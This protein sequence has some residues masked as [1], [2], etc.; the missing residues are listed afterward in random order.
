[1][2][3]IYLVLFSFLVLLPACKN[4]EEVA[5]YSDIIFASD[6]KSRNTQENSTFEKGNV[7]GIFA[8]VNGELLYSNCKYI[9]NGS[10]FEADG[11]ENNIRVVIGQNVKF[12]AYYPYSSSNSDIGNIVYT[13]SNQETKDKWLAADFL[14]ATTEQNIKGFEVPLHFEHRMAT[15]T[16]NVNQSDADATSATLKDVKTSISGNLKTG[17]FTTLENTSNLKFCKL[18]ESNGI[19]NFIITIPPQT[20]TIENNKVNLG[21]AT[22]IDVKSVKDFDAVAGKISNYILEYRKNIQIIDYEPG[23]TTSGG[24]LHVIGTECSVSV[25]LN[26][27]YEFVGW[28]DE[29]NNLLSD[30]TIYTFQVKDDITLYPK[31]RNYEDWTLSI[32]NNCPALIP[33]TGGTYNLSA[34]ATRGIFINGE[35]QPGNEEVD[36]TGNLQSNNTYFVINHS[37]KTLTVAQNATITNRIAKITVSYANKS[38]EIQLTQG[39]AE[40]KYG[41]WRVSVSATGTVSA[42]AGSTPIIAGAERDV[43]ISGIIIETEKATPNL[44]VSGTGFSISGTTLNYEENKSSA[45]RTATITATHGGK[46]ATCSVTQSAAKITT[47]YSFSAT[48]TTLSFVAKPTSGQTV[49][50]TSTKTVTINVTPST[51]SL[52]YSCTS[53]PSWV[54]VNANTISANENK[55]ESPRSGKIVFTQAESNKTIE[56]TVSQSA[57][58][59][60]YG[61]KTLDGITVSASPNNIAAKNSSLITFTIAANYSQQKYINGVNSETIKSTEYPTTGHSLSSNQSWLSISGMKGSASENMNTTT[62]T[63]TITAGYGGKSATCTVTQSAA[64]IEYKNYSF[65]VSPISMSFDVE[66]ETKTF[67]VTSTREVYIN[68]SYSQ[69]ENVGYTASA[70]GSGLTCTKTS[71]TFSA[72]NTSSR[73]T[74]I[75]TLTQETSGN[76][77][78][79]ECDQDRW[80]NVGN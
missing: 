31:Y 54:D 68:G 49:T 74:G 34:K 17:I 72:N 56:I 52:G 20:L 73:R 2:R 70:S 9:Y 32:S 64:I 44:Y 58:S 14:T 27:G 43:T 36:I 6:I 66:G 79:I 28:F 46:N 37:S 5:Q 75:I 4:D 71:A 60:T 33:Y 39:I 45:T 35:K 47:E 42:L 69:K 62:R 40:K 7:I 12:Y 51:T 8:E 19:G 30:K 77:A 53:K 38:Q 10:T 21:G 55:A 15:V 78:T 25:N 13:V 48:P 76:K 18:G 65:T 61:T 1:M 41:E 11:M 29:S 63:A 22:N 16:M 24:G 67:T 3:T 26:N 57:A 59:I 50:I 23:G 80:Y